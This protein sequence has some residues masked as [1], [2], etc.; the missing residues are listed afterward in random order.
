MSQTLL[1]IG[2]ALLAGVVVAVYQVLQS[3]SAE[4]PITFDDGV[5]AAVIGVAVAALV[6]G[7]GWL[8]RKFGPPVAP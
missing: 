2:Q 5:E 6:R 7:A 3:V 4:H 1:Q 8:V